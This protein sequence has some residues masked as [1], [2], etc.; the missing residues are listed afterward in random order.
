MTGC[1]VYLS[2][3]NEGLCHRNELNRVVLGRVGENGPEARKRG[4]QFWKDVVP[5]QYQQWKNQRASVNAVSAIAA[6]QSY[7]GAYSYCTPQIYTTQ[8]DLV[9]ISLGKDADFE[10]LE[11]S[12]DEMC[13]GE[14]F[15]INR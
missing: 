9:G 15:A 14:V 7:S 3:Q 13:K 12:E 2:M 4:D 8:V 11:E 10:G 6:P 1:P 5:D